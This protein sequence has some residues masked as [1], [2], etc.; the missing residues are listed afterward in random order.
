MQS[1]IPLFVMP[2]TLMHAI[3]EASPLYGFGPDKML[4][5]DVRLFLSLDAR[6]QAIDTTVYDMKLYTVPEIRFGMRYAESVTMDEHG[7]A[8]ADLSQLSVLE[9]DEVAQPE[10]AQWLR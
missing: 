8:T 3:D 4:A 10:W 1:H 6:D 7:H 9:P 2:W 5:A